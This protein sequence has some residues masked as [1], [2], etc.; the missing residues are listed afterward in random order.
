MYKSYFF[1]TTVEEIKSIWCQISQ[2][3]K[4]LCVYSTSTA[5]STSSPQL[6]FF[7]LHSVP[8]HH[9]SWDLQ[10]SRHCSWASTH[11][12]CHFAMQIFHSCAVWLQ[13][14]YIKAIW[15]GCRNGPGPLW[16]EVCLFGQVTVLH[17]VHSGTHTAE[18]MNTAQGTPPAS[19]HQEGWGCSVAMCGQ[20]THY[21]WSS[22]QTAYSYTLRSTYPP[23]L[24]LWVVIAF[25]SSS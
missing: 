6:W 21:N 5:V 17:T 4:M 15:W 2:K 9:E 22:R 10:K 16:G 3:T 19:R 23:V 11:C 24:L 12:Q 7:P 8:H 20:H 1:L 14:E 13:M 25:I 18:K